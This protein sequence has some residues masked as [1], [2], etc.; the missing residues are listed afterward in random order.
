MTQV[1]RI[2]VTPGPFVGKKLFA[3]EVVRQK[4][5]SQRPPDGKGLPNVKPTQINAQARDRGHILM[6]VSEPLYPARTEARHLQ[7]ISVM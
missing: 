2:K 7:A 4:N 3:L 5:R 6:M 1:Y